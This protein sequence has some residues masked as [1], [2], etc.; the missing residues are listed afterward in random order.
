MR[1]WMVISA[2]FSVASVV[3]GFSMG[4]SA[5]GADVHRTARLHM[6]SVAFHLQ[7]AHAERGD[8]CA[9]SQG[10]TGLLRT[11]DRELYRQWL[12]RQENRD[13]VDPHKA[14]ARSLRG[15]GPSQGSLLTPS[16]TGWRAAMRAAR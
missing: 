11:N 3:L 2:A 5:G 15:R 16:P 12:R 6:A 14:P 9:E 13:G 10:G 8:G 7:V 1:A 4:A